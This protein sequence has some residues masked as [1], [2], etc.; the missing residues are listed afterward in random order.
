M[1]TLYIGRLHRFQEGRCDNSKPVEVG[2]S[3]TTP[4]SNSSNTYYTV[5][6]VPSLS[7]ENFCQP[8]TG[9]AGDSWYYCNDVLPG[10]TTFQKSPTPNPHWPNMTQKDPKTKSSTQPILTILPWS[11]PQQVRFGFICIIDVGS[12]SLQ[13]SS[14]EAASTDGS[15]ASICTTRIGIPP[16]TRGALPRWLKVILRFGTSATCGRSV[17]VSQI[18]WQHVGTAVFGLERIQSWGT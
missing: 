5:L 17:T 18:G 15:P 6:V 10:N 3:P 4:I 8:P 7:L 14:S 16:S 12:S 13:A 2:Y 11:H 9:S 1:F